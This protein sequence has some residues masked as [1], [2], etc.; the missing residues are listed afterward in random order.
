MVSRDLVVLAADKDIDF[1]L[2]GL[3]RRPK[4]LGIRPIDAQTFVHPRRDP[5]C[6]R[7]AHEFLQP[8]AADFNH[9]L[10]LFDHVGCGRES[11]DATRLAE[12][13]KGRLAVHG[14]NDRAEAVLIAP[15]LEVWVFADSPHVEA[16][17]E[18]PRRK[19]RIRHWLEKQGLWEGILPKP[20]QPRL[21]LERILYEAKRARS[22]ALYEHLAR[23]VGVK[24]CVDPSFLRLRSILGGWFPP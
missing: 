23:R 24:R 22:A 18:W 4:A 14:W 3:L 16:C 1:G 8:L 7:E 5:G 15:E 2:R 6:L 21:A 17:L 19:G 9:A 20:R 13:V 10:V 11:D 12:E